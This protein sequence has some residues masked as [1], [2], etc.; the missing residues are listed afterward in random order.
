[1]VALAGAGAL[2]TATVLVLQVIPGN[3]VGQVQPAATPAPTPYE[4]V[5]TYVYEVGTSGSTVLSRTIDLDPLAVTLA[6]SARNVPV[7]D[8]FDATATVRLKVTAGQVVADLRDVGRPTIQLIASGG[9]WSIQARF[10]TMGGSPGLPSHVA[11]Q[12]VD[13]TPPLVAVAGAVFS[14]RQTFRCE[15]LGESLIS[16]RAEGRVPAEQRDRFPFPGYLSSG[17]GGSLLVESVASIATPSHS[18]TRTPPTPA[19]REVTADRIVAIFNQSAFTTRYALTVNNPDRQPLT[20]RWAGPNCG[21]W[22]NQ[23]PHTSTE[24]TFQ[25]AMAWSHPHPP[26]AATT[27][28]SEVQVSLSIGYQGGTLVCV[29]NGSESGNG[30]ECK[31]L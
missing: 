6:G 18:P 3:G 15:S 10:I 30:P 1:M 13:N 22:D 26:C 12:G 31:K 9:P 21:T 16:Y 11:P 24:T 25:E 23:A 20:L 19:A 5:S 2:L 4:G 28:H 29:Y 27:N 8:S 14:V 7:G 17:P